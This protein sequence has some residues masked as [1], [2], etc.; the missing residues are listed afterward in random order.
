LSASPDYVYTDLGGGPFA[1][2]TAVAVLK[3]PPGRLLGT[4]VGR[5]P[6]GPGLLTVCQLPLA[7][8]ALEGDP[9]ARALIS[10]LLRWSRS[11]L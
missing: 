7:D 1:V 3:P 8:A 5:M 2:E 9:L 11:P 4:V 10:D 6:V